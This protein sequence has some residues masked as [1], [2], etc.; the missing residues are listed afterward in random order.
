MSYTFRFDD[1]D[2]ASGLGGGQ[3]P[4]TGA[5][6]AA[7]DLLW[8]TLHPYDAE[9]DLGNDLFRQDGQIQSI[10]GGSAFHEQFV[11]NAMRTS[12]ERLMRAQARS[13]LTSPS[14]LIQSIVK[15]VVKSPPGDVSRVAFFEEV[16]VDGEVIGTKPRAFT[17]NHLNGRR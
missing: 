1:G 5:E 17:L 7:Q 3:V 14:E 2:F 9:T 6:K 15:I 12:T 13:L 8:E 16:V 11:E 10:S 4:I